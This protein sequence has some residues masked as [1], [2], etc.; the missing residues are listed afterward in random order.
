VIPS[1]SAAL[2]EGRCFICVLISSHVSCGSGMCESEGWGASKSDCTRV[3][4]SSSQGGAGCPSRSWPRAYLY[5]WYHCFP[6]AGSLWMW[7][8]H[9]SLLSVD[10]PVFVRICEGSWGLFSTS[11]DL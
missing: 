5:S 2:S 9:H 6:R 1:G 10:L 8:D 4:S 7:C 11:L 3:T